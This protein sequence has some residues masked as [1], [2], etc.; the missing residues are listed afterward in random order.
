VRSARVKRAVE[1]LDTEVALVDR[2]ER[3]V[4]SVPEAAEILGIS[5]RLTY[6]LAGRGELPAV[7]LGGRIVILLRPLER[8]LDGDR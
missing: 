4:L 7:R 5:R 6:Q 3:L 1:I 8:L 2:P